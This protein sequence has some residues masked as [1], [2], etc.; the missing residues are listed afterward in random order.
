MTLGRSSLSSSLGKGGSGSTGGDLTTTMFDRRTAWAMVSVD[1][2]ELPSAA[3]RIVSR[4]KHLRLYPSFGGSVRP[5][6]DLDIDVLLVPLKGEPSSRR[7]LT[8]LQVEVRRVRDAD[9]VLDV[10]GT[11]VSGGTTLIISGRVHAEAAHD[12]LVLQDSFALS[13]GTVDVKVRARNLTTGEYLMRTGRGRIEPQGKHGVTVAEPIAVQRREGSMLRA[14]EPETDSIEM[15]IGNGGRL[16]ADVDAALL[17]SVCHGR[18]HSGGLTVERAFFGAEGIDLP[19]VGIP[20]DGER[21]FVVEDLIPGGTLRPGRVEYDVRV[22]QGD[23]VEAGR[24]HAFE[25][26]ARPEPGRR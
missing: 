21:C 19:P 10:V 26:A 23:E 5:A 17:T 1:V 8:L 3:L 9:E 22:L 20:A 4:T 18:D 15:V 7:V 13:P 11:V 2:D 25:L 16:D 6:D 14:G 12:L 24:R